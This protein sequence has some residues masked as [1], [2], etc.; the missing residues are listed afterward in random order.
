VAQVKL[1]TEKILRIR[2]FN[3]ANFS[4]GAGVLA[5]YGIFMSWIT[6]FPVVFFVW[7]GFALPMKKED[8]AI[9]YYVLKRRLNRILLPICLVLFALFHSGHRNTVAVYCGPNCVHSYIPLSLWV[10][11]FPT[12]GIFA[13]ARLSAAWLFKSDPSEFTKGAFFWWLLGVAFMLTIVGAVGTFVFGFISEI[14]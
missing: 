1:Q 11:F 5:F 13:A 2:P 6:I 9:D 14:L 12:V 4:S 8:G 7:L 10:A 3:R